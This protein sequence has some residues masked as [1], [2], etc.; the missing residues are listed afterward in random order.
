MNTY[1]KV[2]FWSFLI[3]GAVCVFIGAYLFP[4]GPDKRPI[5]ELLLLAGAGQLIIFAVLFF[6]RYRRKSKGTAN[7]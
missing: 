6:L 2:K 4:F 1:T 5:A 3:V 7:A